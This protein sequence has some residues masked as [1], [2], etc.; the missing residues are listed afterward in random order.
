MCQPETRLKA[1]ERSLHEAIDFPRT[2]ESPEVERVFCTRDAR[3]NWKN[4]AGELRLAAAFFLV[5]ASDEFN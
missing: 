4:R 1:R 2:R 3:G 5:Y